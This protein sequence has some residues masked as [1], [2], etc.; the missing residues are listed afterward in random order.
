MKKVIIRTAQA[1]VFYGQL[2]SFKDGVAEIIGC[3]RLWYWEGAASL[4]QLAVEGVGKPRECKF[5]PKVP[6]HRVLG[7]IEIIDTTAKAQESI[8][9]VPDWRV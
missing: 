6:R 4:S 7:V 5:P 8:E 1:G 3:R 2:K 9:S